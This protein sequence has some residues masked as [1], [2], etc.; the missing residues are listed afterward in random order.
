[1]CNSE[2][3]QKEKLKMAVTTEK[4]RFFRRRQNKRTNSFRKDVNL[5][6]ENASTEEIKDGAQASP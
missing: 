3:I 5:I 1:M 4:F 6:E 2:I